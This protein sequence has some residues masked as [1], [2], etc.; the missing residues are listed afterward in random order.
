[1]NASRLQPIEAARRFLVAK[2]ADCQAALLAGS[3]VRGEETETSDLDIVVFDQK[4]ELAYRES[5]IPH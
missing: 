2:F 5:F 4:V 3:V 1:M